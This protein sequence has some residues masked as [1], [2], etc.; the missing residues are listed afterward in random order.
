MATVVS[1]TTHDALIVDIADDAQYLTHFFLALQQGYLKLSHGMFDMYKKQ[2]PSPMIRC[3]TGGRKIVYIEALVKANK[4][5][6]FVVVTCRRT[7]TDSLAGR[8]GFD[9]Y[10]GIPKG[11][12]ACNR[13]VIQAELSCRLDMTFYSENTVLILDEFSSLIKH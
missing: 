7:L 2:S 5:F 12:I 9:N 13:V 11:M 6:K 10:Q 8:F 4:D 3:D 1:Q